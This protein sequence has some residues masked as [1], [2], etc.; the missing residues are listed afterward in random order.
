MDNIL[1]AILAQDTAASVI[2]L[3]QQS[4]F[5]QIIQDH[6]S[7]IIGIIT[8]AELVSGSQYRGK[9]KRSHYRGK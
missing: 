6:A 2:T 9:Y 1:S 8:Y 7:L 5:D 4:S 3:T